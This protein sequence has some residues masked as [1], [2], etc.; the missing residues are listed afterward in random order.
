M[1]PMYR[2][3]MQ[4]K[5]APIR[6]RLHRNLRLGAVVILVMLLACA[7]L[8]RHRLERIYASVHQAVKVRR[9]RL[10]TLVTADHKSGQP[11]IVAEL[12][13]LHDLAE[14]RA[15]VEQRSKL[16]Q[17]ELR[18]L[19]AEL[20]RRQASGENLA[21]SAR[22]YRELRW[23]V[24]FSADTN[25]ARARIADLR[26]SLKEPVDQAVTAQQLPDGSWGAGYEVWFMKLYGT[27]NDGLSDGAVPKYPLSFLDRINSPEKLTNH[28]AGLVVNDFL[29]TGVAN[30]MEADET[31]ALLGR[32]L[33]GDVPCP[34]AFAP[35]VKEAYLRFVDD[36]QNQDTGCWGNLFVARD[37]TLWRMDDIGMTF[38]VV[39]RLKQNTKHLDKIARRVLEL[40]TVDFPAG[41][42]VKGHYE[43]HLNWD[44]VRIFSYA[45]PALDE[46]TRAAA[47]V[48]LT[49][50]LNWC[51]TE[52]LQADG[53][54]K[55]SDLDDTFT[56]AMEYGVCFLRDIGFFSKEK[57]FWTDQSFP[58]AENIHARIERRLRSAGAHPGQVGHEGNEV[59]K[60]NRNVE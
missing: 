27:V 42:R 18:P 20:T 52:S 32:L 48:E 6:G 29:K 24:A 31:V 21:Y 11:G 50:M 17:P 1:Q 57:R 39:S 30:R 22:I 55:V 5:E 9:L 14:F 8:G 10:F 46:R 40:S 2:R 38:H 15:R 53:A 54:F 13:F 47:R 19:A 45:W 36:W 56:D 59:N 49:R 44:A 4:P 16:L 23:R 37:G 3:A 34:Y 33:C 7:W 41:M 28:L 25:A 35:G 43:N 51:L 12:R 58:E 60:D 26:K